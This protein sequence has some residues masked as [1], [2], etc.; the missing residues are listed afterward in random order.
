MNEKYAI[1]GNKVFYLY[2]TSETEFPEGIMESEDIKPG[3]TSKYIKGPLA[4]KGSMRLF[5]IYQI[6]KFK[7]HITI[8]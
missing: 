5:D 7:S 2:D 6:D 1:Q 4:I 3:T 8:C